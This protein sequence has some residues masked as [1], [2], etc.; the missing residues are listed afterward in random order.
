MKTTVAFS[1]ISLLLALLTSCESISSNGNDIKKATALGNQSTTFRIKIIDYSNETPK[2][3]SSKN[4]NM[5]VKVFDSSKLD[6][7][8]SENLMVG[9]IIAL[10]NDLSSSANETY[11]KLAIVSGQKTNWKIL[12][13]GPKGNIDIY[14]LSF[15]NGAWEV[16]RLSNPK[17]INSNALS[18]F[19][20]NILN[21]V[22]KYSDSQ[23]CGVVGL[24]GTGMISNLSAANNHQYTNA[25]LIAAAYLFAGVELH[26]AKQSGLFET[27]NNYQV[28]HAV[29]Q[30]LDNCK[31]HLVPE[32]M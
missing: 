11:K 32:D 28:V 8:L 18:K 15:L 19:E 30:E 2:P 29:G 23:F 24:P 27:I 12:T 13:L 21:I 22:K 4:R 3:L 25:S 31:Y 20:E 9:D 1:I 5:L 16:F 14:P 7:P 17:A 10:K 6:M 26:F